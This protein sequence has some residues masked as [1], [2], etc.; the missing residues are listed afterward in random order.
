MN[1]RTLVTAPPCHL[2]KGVRAASSRK[3]RYFVR[4]SDDNSYIHPVT[5]LSAAVPDLGSERGTQSD[6]LACSRYKA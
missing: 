1:N 2:G 4:P 6:L 5:V 3:V